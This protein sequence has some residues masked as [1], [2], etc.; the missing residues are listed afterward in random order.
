[1]IFYIRSIQKQIIFFL[2][3]FLN[4]GYLLCQT[5]LEFTNPVVNLSK[6]NDPEITYPVPNVNIYNQTSSGYLFAAPSNYIIIFDNQGVPVFYRNVEGQVYDFKLQPNGELTYFIYPVDCYGLDS[7]LNFVRKYTTTNGYSEDVHDLIVLPNGHYFILG[8][9]LVDVDM[10]EIVPGGDSTAQIIDMALQ[11][12]DSSGNVVFQWSALDHYKITDAD[13]H[14]SLLAHTIDFVHLNS[15]EIDTDS[16]IILSA[17][18][19]NEITKIDYQTGDIIWRLGGENNQFTFIND[20]IGF[21]RQHDA[22]RLSNGNISL[23]DNGV[24]HNEKHSSFV[25]YKIDEQAKTAELIKRYLHRKNIYTPSRGNVQELPNGNILIGWGESNTPAITEINQD[26]SIV[27]EISFP[28]QYNLYRS[29]RFEWETNLFKINADSLNFGKI[30]FGDSV[31]KTITLYNPHD[32]SVIINE[33]FYKDSSFSIKENLPLN[34]LPRDSITLTI[35]FKPKTHGIFTDRLNIRSVDDNQLI[36][37]QLTMY[38]STLSLINPIETPVNLKAAE[39]SVNEVLLSWLDKSDNEDGFVIERKSGDSL[40]INNFNIIDTVGFNDTSYIDNSI[41]DSSKFTYRIYGYNPDTTSEYSNLA[42]IE[43]IT[44]IKDKT[45]PELFVLR[46]NYPNPFNPSTIIKYEIPNSGFVTLKIY[47]AL[48]Q[49]IKT[50]VNEFQNSGKYSV[51]FNGSNLS[52]G[53][54]FYKL[55]TKNH[56]AIKKFILM[57]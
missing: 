21:S 10:S 20:S 41:T 24:Y 38:G 16:N 29:F 42:Y 28:P 18:N 50:I 4:S 8:K 54:Y 13:S 45:V 12:F 34:I 27:C 57:K 9:R 19:L 25:E 56:T 43:I 22:R 11:E 39:L 6:I 30:S 36:A 55:T 32:S 52:S 40:S 35:K 17:R 33:F 3:I 47:N 5:N 2:I 1:M 14:I 15:I 51:E 31:F 23:F 7:S 37:K 44:S 48:G 46:Q 53:I 49:E 26:D